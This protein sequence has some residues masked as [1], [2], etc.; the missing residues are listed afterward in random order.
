M[1]PRTTLIPASQQD[2]RSENGL[3]SLIQAR[4]DAVAQGDTELPTPEDSRSTSPS[5]QSPDDSTPACSQN[6]SASYRRSRTSLP[7]SM[8]GK[9]LFDARIWADPIQ[10]SIFHTFIAAL[11]KKIREDV[12]QTTQTH[13]LIRALRDGGRL[14]RCYTQ[15]ID[16]LEARDG[17]C[18]DMRK[19]K[20]NRS[21]FLRRV[22]ESPRPDTPILSGSEMDGGCEVVQLH[23]DLDVL[24]CHL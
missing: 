20:G 19:G 8:K 18:T 9:D 22:T 16:G 4:F 15:N 12:A 5:S 10:T 6:S 24:R 11:R 1:A 2:F 23:G 21:R 17:L 13:K 14:V 7:A 3:Y